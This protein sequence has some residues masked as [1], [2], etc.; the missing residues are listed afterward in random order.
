MKDKVNKVVML[1]GYTKAG[2]DTFYETV[3][4]SLKEYNIYRMSFADS[5]KEIY[6][7]KFEVPK[8]LLHST[9][10][11]DEHRIGLIELAENMRKKDVDVFVR[12]A[13]NDFVEYLKCTSDLR[14]VYVIVTDFRN[15][16]EHEYLK[17]IF[18]DKLITVKIKNLEKPP[19]KYIS[20]FYLE[21]FKTDYCLENYS[22]LPNYQI[23][24]LNF[25][26]KII[27]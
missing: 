19:K 21:N 27:N 23:A 22:T 11:K 15:L 25:F 6:A 8:M 20:E 13:Y 2:K 7:S 14:P 1:C 16:N 18:K 9:K 3:S 12:K 10:H 17:A 26:K 4:K 24:C 5:L